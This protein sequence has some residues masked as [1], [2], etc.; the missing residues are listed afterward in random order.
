M[1]VA[2]KDLASMVVTPFA[3]AIN[4]FFNSGNTLQNTKSF[5]KDWFSEKEIKLLI[6]CDGF[7]L[8]VSFL[9]QSEANEPKKGEARCM[10][11]I[12]DDYTAHRFFVFSNNAHQF[13]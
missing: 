2:L 1:D 8:P 10:I 9:T 11:I 4:D 6:R 3:Q 12:F 13:A 7:Q 5:W